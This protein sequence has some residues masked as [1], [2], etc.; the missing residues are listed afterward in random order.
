MNT[1]DE[2]AAKIAEHER[3]I[4]ELRKQR[5][6]LVPELVASAY[7]PD[8]NGN[9]PMLKEVAKA[10]GL[11]T[12]VVRRAIAEQTPAPGD[13]AL[14][15]VILQRRSGIATTYVSISKELRISPLRVRDLQTIIRRRS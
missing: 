13:D 8:A 9:W 11:Q 4:V 12:T 5:H 7:V 10:L 3:E 6:S 1:L 14:L 15:E 2:V